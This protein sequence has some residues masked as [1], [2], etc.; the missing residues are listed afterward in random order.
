MKPHWA[1]VRDVLECLARMVDGL[2]KD[3]VDLTFPF[4]QDCNLRNIKGKKL[5]QDSWDQL[6]TAVDDAKPDDSQDRHTDMAK[7]LG[8]IF[9]KYY[10]GNMTLIVLTDG[11]W[12]GEAGYT[13][14]EKKIA[15]FLNSQAKQNVQEDRK[16]SIEFVSFGTANAAKL[17]R[18]DND[19]KTLYNVP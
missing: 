18:L 12:E 14:T 19:M 5:R 16:V 13:E 2:D 8:S 6:L 15:T 9:D 1:E 17:D 7:L 4:R 11:F 3:G 10:T